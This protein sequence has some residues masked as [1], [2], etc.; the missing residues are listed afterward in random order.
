MGAYVGKNEQF[1]GLLHDPIDKVISIRDHASR[2]ADIAKR[3][4]NNLPQTIV[5]E[6]ENHHQKQVKI[7][8]ADHNASAAN[9]GLIPYKSAVYKITFQ[10][11][12]SAYLIELRRL[13]SE[14]TI[15]STDQFKCIGSYSKGF[16]DIFWNLISEYYRVYSGINQALAQSLFILPEDTRIPSSPI[17]SHLTMTN[18]LA[19]CKGNFYL[20]YIDIGGVQEFI[21]GARKTRD[22]WA[23]SYIYSLLSVS[24]IK[25]LVN[26]F[27]PD[28]VIM[29]WIL[30]I[31]LVE[32]FI[33]EK[34]KPRRELLLPLV[35]STITALVPPISDEKFIDKLKEEIYGVLKRTWEKILNE[36][37][38]VL[39]TLKITSIRDEQIKSQFKFDK[40]FPKVRILIIEYEKASKSNLISMLDELGHYQDIRRIPY[41][42]DRKCSQQQNCLAYKHQPLEN[43]ENYIKILQI[44][45]EF[46][47][48]TIEFKSKPEIDTTKNCQACGKHRQAVLSDEEWRKLE[49]EYII[50]Y[51]ERLC[52]LCLLKR[53]L[54]RFIHKILGLENRIRITVPSTSDLGA[55]W[56]KVSLVSL[57]LASKNRDIRQ[58]IESIIW[59]L[60]KC[61]KELARECDLDWRIEEW[62]ERYEEHLQPLFITLF[63][64]GKDIRDD[65][66][67]DLVTIV[68]APGDLFDPESIRALISRKYPN[69]KEKIEKSIEAIERILERIYEIPEKY[70]EKIIDEAKKVLANV[71]LD[72]LLG[73]D[74]YKDIYKNILE[75]FFELFSFKNNKFINAIPI[76]L[77]PQDSL[78]FCIIRGDGDSIGKWINGEKCMSWVLMHHPDIIGSVQSLQNINKNILE[79][80]RPT[81]PAYLSTLS[82]TLSYN[83]LLISRIIDAFGGFLIYTGGDDVLALV[84]PEVWHL[85]Y[86]ILRYTFSSEI[87]LNKAL[88]RYDNG[89]YMYGLSWRAT[90]SYGVVIAHHKADLRWVI[91]YSRKLEERSKEFSYNCDNKLK[92]NELKDS[93]CVALLGRGVVI[94]ETEALPNTLIK[95]EGSKFYTISEFDNKLRNELNVLSSDVFKKYKENVERILTIIPA[96]SLGDDFAFIG[97]LPRKYNLADNDKSCEVYSIPMF[98]YYISYLVLNGLLSRSGLKLLEELYETTLQRSLKDVDLQLLKYMLSRRVSEALRNELLN[99]ILDNIKILSNLSKKFNSN[100]LSVFYLAE[101]FRRCL[102]HCIV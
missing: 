98:G 22:F 10:N 65:L 85:V 25:Y 40:I 54:D 66:K 53:L 27:G 34:V 72:V 31:P 95:E 17:L 3:L 52:H 42:E 35:P 77:K 46:V 30:D 83:A 99:T 67:E 62:K 57:Y 47:K 36:Y 78:R 60:A 84:P 15:A 93:I 87:I 1:E 94:R 18:A 102:I 48:D 51:D 12:F 44:G 64:L 89:I 86:L 59:E 11:P 39:K 6:I 79:R 19:K 100:L 96:E 33:F 28:S 14:I 26:R 24:I 29:P 45:S 9:R 2:A 61:L 81:S 74:K 101:I 23:G 41:H 8:W 71:I 49:N 4:V 73:G 5:N 82:M 55:T 68:C 43:F 90:Q 80:P 92:K 32:A 50:D 16:K 20:L 38:N 70:G 56:F 13:Q 7:T 37:I 69:R 91:E 58:Y 21:S 75:R 97:I 88:G 76:A 63:N